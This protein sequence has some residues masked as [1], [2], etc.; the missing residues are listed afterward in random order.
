MTAPVLVTRDPA[1]LDELRR[2]AAAAGVPLET[3]RQVGTALRRWTSA[4]LVLVGTDVGVE[5]AALSPPRRAQ[6]LLVGTAPVPDAAFRTAVALGVDEVV[7]V[8]SR[9]AW[10]TELLTD[11]GDDDPVPGRVVGVVAGSGGAGATTF[12]CALAQVAARDGTAVVVDTDPLGPGAD[13]VLGLDGCPGVRW[14]DLGETSGR[15]GARSLRDALPSRAGLAALT[16]ETGTLGELAPQVVRESLSA[17]R[18]GHALV[19]V[20]LARSADP[21]VADVALRCD[22]LVVVARSTV[23]S[24]AATVRVVGRFAD[25]P[26][27][28]LVARGTETVAEQVASVAGLPLLATMRDQRGLVE[29]VDLGLGPVRGRRGPLARAARCVLDQVAG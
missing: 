8:P 7:E 15:L 17:A 1:L 27:V 6:V 18:R 25:H 10:L 29:R 12:A 20:D 21:L 9:S 28:S 13:R 5:L 16:W 22:A 26:S 24:A 23:A 4:P 3:E 19:V 14:G 11:L 2:L